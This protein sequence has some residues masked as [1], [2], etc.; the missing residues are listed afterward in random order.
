MFPECLEGLDGTA[1]SKRRS[2][3]DVRGE[4]SEEAAIVKQAMQICTKDIL[5][6]IADTVDLSVYGKPW[7]GLGTECAQASVNLL[8]VEQLTGK[9]GKPAGFAGNGAG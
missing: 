8:A 7:N 6:R 3:A 1:V 9:S 5:L 4:S 2:F